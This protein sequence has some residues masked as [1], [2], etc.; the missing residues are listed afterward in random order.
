MLSLLCFFRKQWHG[1][2]QGPRWRTRQGGR[3]PSLMRSN[4]GTLTLSS[5]EI[6]EYSVQ[7]VS[8]TLPESLA[9]PFV[10][11]FHF[12]WEP[13]DCKGILSG[14]CGALSKM[15]ELPGGLLLPGKL[16]GAHFSRCHLRCCFRKTAATQPFCSWADQPALLREIKCQSARC[17][18]GLLLLPCAF[19][20]QPALAAALFIPHFWFSYAAGSVR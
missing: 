13:G 14:F 15:L 6:Y 20:V 7:E 19:A 1:L 17:P 2:L 9:I 12:T 18:W 11:E 10:P 5:S 16:P 8:G 4:A 3:R